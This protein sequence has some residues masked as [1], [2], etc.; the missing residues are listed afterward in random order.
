MAEV[1]A[2]DP[3]ADTDQADPAATTAAAT[4]ATAVAQPQSCALTE[5]AKSG[6]IR[7]QSALLT[8]R[9]AS[10]DRLLFTDRGISLNKSYC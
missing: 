6:N 5:L 1:T 10:V 7:F 2:A 9:M 4:A 3:A 8:G